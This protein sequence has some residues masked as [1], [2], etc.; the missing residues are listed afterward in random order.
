MLKYMFLTRDKNLPIKILSPAS[1]FLNQNKPT[2]RAVFNEIVCM[3]SY[4]DIQACQLEYP[5]Y[6]LP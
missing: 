5:K 4:F 2:I 3:S 6:D 1:L